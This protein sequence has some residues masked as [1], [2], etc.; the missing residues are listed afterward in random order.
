M[1]KTCLKSVYNA[2]MRKHLLVLVLL[3][4][5]VVGGYTRWSARAQGSDVRYFPETGHTIRGP[6]RTFYESTPDALLLFGYPITEAFTNEG[7]LEVQYFQKARFEHNPAA[8]SDVVQL[9]PLGRLLYNPYAEHIQPDIPVSATACHYFPDTRQNLCYDF[10]TY[11]EAHGGERYLGK[12]I[13]PL[14]K[15]NDRLVQYLEYARLEWHPENISKAQIVT[16]NLGEI[17]FRVNGENPALLRAIGGSFIAE[18][19]VTRLIVNAFV[20]QASVSHHDE[21]K[22]YVIVRDQNKQPITNAA[23]DI[24]LRYPDGT[25]AKY[26]APK[27][28]NQAG[29]T[30]IP[31]EVNAAENVIGTVE[32]LVRVS[33][34][35]DLHTETSTSFRIWY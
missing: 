19:R 9:T 11:W 15:E 31:I 1:L 33:V 16:A 30:V 8:L 34:S 14:E 17:Y 10:L 2:C 25:S 22:L 20:T 27:N 26:I 7:G 18:Q 3:L 12:P 6:F 4:T 5:V 28:T 35:P 13:S 23:V 24:T 32:V 21:Q 29:F